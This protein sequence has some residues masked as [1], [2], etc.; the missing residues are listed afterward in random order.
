MLIP[1]NLFII[2]LQQSF[3]ILLS[4]NIHLNFSYFWHITAGCFDFQV[5]VYLR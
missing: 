3:R 2:S 5:I 4:L 1:G